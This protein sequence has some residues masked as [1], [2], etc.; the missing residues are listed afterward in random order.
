MED[1]T[2]ARDLRGTRI[3]AEARLCEVG[4]EPGTRGAAVAA[5]GLAAVNAVVGREPELI[6]DEPELRG[7]TRGRTAAQIGD[8]PGAAGAAVAGPQLDA[9]IAAGGKPER[10]ARDEQ[11]MG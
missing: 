10:A 8:D 5:M 7:R 4:D 9:G 1:G 11:L 3:A 6:A 2:H